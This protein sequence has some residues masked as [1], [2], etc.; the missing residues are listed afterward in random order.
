MYSVSVT[1]AYCKCLANP[2]SLSLN[3]N[4]PYINLS[5]LDVA[6]MSQ[7]VGVVEYES[8]SRTVKQLR[9]S[10]CAGTLNVCRHNFNEP[11]VSLCH[12]RESQL[13]VSQCPLPLESGP[14]RSA[15]WRL[16]LPWRR[17]RRQYSDVKTFRCYICLCTVYQSVF[18]TWPL[19]YETSYYVA[20]VSW[21]TRSWSGPIC[22]SDD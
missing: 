11:A 17:G 7:R 4:F 14:I 20:L 12:C 2:P 15:L 19:D 16:R 13:H 8:W 9:Y 21:T 3:S 18:N 5:F 6:N 22:S 1:M 10:M